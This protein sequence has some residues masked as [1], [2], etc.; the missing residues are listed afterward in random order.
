MDLYGVTGKGDI[1]KSRL[2]NK[3]NKPRKLLTFEIS[4]PKYKVLFMEY[5]L[6]GIILDWVPIWCLSPIYS[7][8]PY[9]LPVFKY[10]PIHL[11]LFSLLLL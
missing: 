3:P 7:T 2:Y 5:W 10:I 4:W 6:M 8:I 1:V 11:T 9:Q